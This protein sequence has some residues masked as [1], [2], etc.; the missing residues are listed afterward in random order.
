MCGKMYV[1]QV[2][3]M[4]ISFFRYGSIHSA[5]VND[6][7]VHFF[8]VYIGGCSTFRRPHIFVELFVETSMRGPDCVK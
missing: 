4:T 7:F 2:Q 5:G 3:H 1:C 8:G 6:V